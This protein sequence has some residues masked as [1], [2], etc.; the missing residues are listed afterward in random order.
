MIAVLGST[1]IFL[2]GNMLFKWT[3]VGKASLSHL[4]GIAILALLMPVAGHFP[5]VILAM[6]ATLVLVLIA[7]W[8]RRR[9]HGSLEASLDKA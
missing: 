1:A 7:A 4:A 8:E 2:V 3:I 6:L 9:R 5:P